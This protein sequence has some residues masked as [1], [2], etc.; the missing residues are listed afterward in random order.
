MKISE[1]PEPIRRLARLRETQPE[2]E[3]DN[4]GCDDLG[5]AF[6]W[7][8]TP[9]GEYFWRQLYHGRNQ[10]IPESSL[11]EIMTIEEIAAMP[12]AERS[13]LSGFAEQLQ[14]LLASEL[15][16]QKKAKIMLAVIKKQV[17]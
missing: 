1:L 6:T 3:G 7:R 5:G 9:E 14:G 4:I 13:E 8:S 15:L 11:Q 2:Y 17:E 12:T 10:K 16:E